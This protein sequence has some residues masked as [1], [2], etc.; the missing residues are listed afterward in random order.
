MA[1]LTRVTSW[2]VTCK[3]NLTGSIDRLLKDVLLESLSISDFG[4]VPETDCSQSIINSML[5]TGGLISV[6][7]GSFVATPTISQVGKVLSSLSRLHI[8]GTLTIKLPRGVST[9]SYP[10]LVELV[11]GNNLSIIGQDRIPLTINSQISV[12]GV[13]GNYSVTLGVST[14]SGVSVGDFLHT[15][16]ATGTGAV[17]MHRGVW[18][19]TSIGSGSITV[20]NTCRLDSFPANTITSSNSRVLTSCLLFDRC[21]GFVVPSSQIGNMSDFVIA[22]NSDSYWSPSAVGTTEL[23]THG[24]TVGSNTIAVNGKLD[25]V[26]PQGKTGA[27][28]TFGQYMGVTGF[29][30]QGIVTELGGNFWGDFTCSCN[31]KRRGFYAS[32]ASGIRAKQISANGNFLDGVISDL[33]GS[34][35]SSS[36]SCALGNGSNGISATQNGVIVWDTGKASYNKLNGSN[37]VA[38]GFLQMT[39]SS[40]VGNVANGSNLTYGAILYCDNA[41]I[42]G[43]GSYGINCQLHSTVRG[44]N[45]TISN[46]GNN[47]I[48]CSYHATVTFTNSVFS[49][50]T[51]GNFLF[52]ASSLGVNGSSNYGGD[53]TTTDVKMVNQTT[54]NGVRL[55]GTSGGDS[56]VLS[57]DTSGS[58]SFVESYSF[59]SDNT[60]FI[61]SDDALKNVGR[62]SNRFNVGFFAGGTQSTSDATLKDPIRDFSEDETNAAIDC[63]KSL[64]FWTWLDDESKRLHAGTTVQSVLSILEKH[65]LDWVDYGF[66]GFDEWDDEFAEDPLSGV[67]VLTRPAGSI[68]QLRDQEFDR[69]L[70]KG[71]SSRL[72]KLEVNN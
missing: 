72:H 30:Q 64:G 41:N 43:N 48:R 24:L 31:N 7:R 14:T 33:G 8:K 59:R 26:N 23:G 19:I 54:G 2:L 55:S 60:G 27:S 21:D 61:P 5:S 38:G 49:G 67:S 25:N 35:Y 1:N 66:I 45:C 16:Q 29:D 22:G 11:G 4:A 71:L 65:G 36:S 13:A 46:N 68:W 20:R 44:P 15:N 42:S 3:N 39:G 50:N 51:N 47:G 17:D 56:I 18:E 34:V 52:T 6:P 10:I 32:T 37:A 28:V 58:G 9:L 12:T 63:S 70:I 62:A 69:F 57:H 53:V 40:M